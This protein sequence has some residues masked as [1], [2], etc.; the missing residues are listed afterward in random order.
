MRYQRSLISILSFSFTSL[1]LV[2]GSISCNGQRPKAN[3]NSGGAGEENVYNQTGGVDC[4]LAENITNP[5]CATSSGDSTG[6]IVDQQ[7]TQATSPRTIDLAGQ[8]IYGAYD[9]GSEHLISCSPDNN[10]NQPGKSCNGWLMEPVDVYNYGPAGN[11]Y[12]STYGNAKII[13]RLSPRDFIDTNL[14]NVSKEDF[15]SKARTYAAGTQG[16]SVWVIGNEP[17]ISGM[18]SSA[19]AALFNECYRQFQGIS[20]LVVPAGIAPWNGNEGGS[21]QY[22]ANMLNG[23][24]NLDGIAVHSK[25]RCNNDSCFGEF[26]FRD[27]VGNIPAKY[28]DRPVFITEAN[29]HDER[30]SGSQGWINKAYDLVNEYNKGT[31]NKKIHA[32]VLFRWD[33][34]NSTQEDSEWEFYGMDSIKTQF[35]NAWNKG[36]TPQH[37]Y[38]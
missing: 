1:F 29:P 21:A 38:Y 36:Y 33:N 23:I 3:F 8:T 31:T 22:F 20:G 25:T 13:I 16:I 6:N 26:D 2:S 27:F 28:A 4:T 30:W 34:L 9:R 11:F 15:C 18:S 5:S 12:A 17:N 35:W 19:Y 37:V 7:Q 14:A 24:D 10:Y 32:V